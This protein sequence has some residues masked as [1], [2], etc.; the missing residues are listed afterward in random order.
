MIPRFYKPAAITVADVRDLTAHWRA[1]VPWSGEAGYRIRPRDLRFVG[2][3]GLGSDQ[4]HRDLAHALVGNL[5]G[6]APCAR[7]GAELMSARPG[8]VAWDALESRDWRALRAMGLP[9]EIAVRLG[10]Y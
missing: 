2:V 7:Y 3:G 9:V 10:G 5:H 4:W 6:R 1:D 8:L